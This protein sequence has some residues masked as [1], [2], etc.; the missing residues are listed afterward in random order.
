M[1]TTVALLRPQPRLRDIEVEVDLPETVPAVVMSESRLQ[2]VLLNLALNGAD[3]M[4]G[5]GKLHLSAHTDDGRAVVTIRDEGHGIP[6]TDLPRI[7][8]P[9][10][11]T[12]EP[13]SGTGLGLSIVERIVQ[14]HGGAIHVKSEV[15][16][17]TCFTV[18]L[19]LADLSEDA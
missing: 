12:K 2:Q 9:F 10:Y 3:A 7:F 18:Y 11:T 17:G 8:D 14:D 4:K 1:E 6:K 15:G 13:G 5:S 16:V 19:P